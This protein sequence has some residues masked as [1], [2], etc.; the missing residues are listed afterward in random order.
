MIY[1]VNVEAKEVANRIVE[2]KVRNHTVRVDQPKEFGAD[3]TAPTPPEMLAISFGSCV[4]STIQFVAVQKNLEVRN[5]RV[6]VTGDID[7]SKALGLSNEN[8]AGFGGLKVGI[9]FDSK[10]SAGEKQ[11]FIKTVFDLGAVIDSIRNT[12]PVAC[13]LL[14]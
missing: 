9:K 6:T 2:C 10:M 3:D 7:F 8:R 11:E 4:V 5:I 14:D 13:E 12:T 1:S